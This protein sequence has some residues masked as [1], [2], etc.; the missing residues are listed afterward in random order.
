MY[1]QAILVEDSVALSDTRVAGENGVAL[2]A[3]VDWSE[4][5]S[6]VSLIPVP[7]RGLRK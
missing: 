4:C 1:G 7:V 3:W 2:S 6:C 5:G